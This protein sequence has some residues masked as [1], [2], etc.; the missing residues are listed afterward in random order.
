MVRVKQI[1]PATL[2]FPK[3]I[4]AR[5]SS[6]RTYPLTLIRED[7]IQHLPLVFIL[8]PTRLSVLPIP[9]AGLL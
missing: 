8:I 7:T 9:R 2:F 1:K 4:M 6:V 3:R 5:L